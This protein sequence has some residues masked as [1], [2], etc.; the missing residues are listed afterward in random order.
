MALIL[1]IVYTLGMVALGV[2]GVHGLL[3]VYKYHRMRPSD[4]ESPR[5]DD[6]GIPP[7]VTVQLPL[8]NE[9]HVATRLLDAVC[10]LE[11]RRDRLQIQVLDD[12][13][14]E[15]TAILAERIAMHRERGLDIEHVRRSTR[16]G[17][18]AGALRDALATATGEMIA[19]FDADFVPAPDFLQRTLPHL[20]ADERLGMVQTRWEHLN[21]DYSL[22][23]RLQ[24]MALDAH[25]AME[26]Q[27]RNRARYFMNFNGTAGVWRRSCIEDAGSW[28]TDTLTEDLDISYR[29]QLRGWR[30]LYLNDVTVPAELPAEINGLKTQQFRWTKGAI[31]TAR[32]LLMTVWRSEQPLSIK[33]QATS[34]LTSNLIFPFILVVALLSVPMVVIKSTYPVYSSWF[35]YLGAFVVGTLS[36]L[37]FYMM[38]QRDITTD[39][40]RRMLVFPIF[41][42]G[43]MGLA[44]SN[45]RAVVEALVRRRSGFERTPKYNVVR[46]GDPWATS[47]Y[48]S[49]RVTL[50]A[51]IEVLI[52]MYLVGGIVLAILYGELAII[53]F[54]LVFLFGFGATGILSMRHALGR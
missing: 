28:H 49:P 4:P 14:D 21:R 18:K 41:I 8:Y 24:A 15:T 53:P 20:I 33:V 42:A 1:L 50:E 40:K 37:L 7:R 34:H 3:M 9:M 2:F 17:F 38:A 25:F 39:W 19:I 52:A 26:Q 43:S 45:T 6:R 44:V 54:Q 29:A 36:T 11:Y 13:T 31:E 12:S 51:V 5:I 16:S 30:F 46:R 32:K 27:V 10:A 23:T 47:R 48:R 35:D 22:L